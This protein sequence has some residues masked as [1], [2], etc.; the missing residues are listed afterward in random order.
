MTEKTRKRAK[1]E[2]LECVSAPL[3]EN[4]DTDLVVWQNNAR[5]AG[6]AWRSGDHAAWLSAISP[7]GLW[8]RGLPGQPA[9]ETGFVHFTHHEVARDLSRNGPL[10]RVMFGD[11][12]WGGPP[13][14]GPDDNPTDPRLA[15]VLLD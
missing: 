15:V 10:A 4:V 9:T 14:L 12:N 7:H 13:R 6:E 2:S 8:V 11:Q 1:S 3:P 5:A